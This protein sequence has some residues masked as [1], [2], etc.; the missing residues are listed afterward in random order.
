MANIVN[1][2]SIQIHFFCHFLCMKLITKRFVRNVFHFLSVQQQ[3]KKQ[4]KKELVIV[5][6]HA[7]SSCV[8]EELLGSVGRSSS[9]VISNAERFPRLVAGGGII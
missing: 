2:Q 1:T 6:L 3:A 5:G 7:L 4:V 9:L 8:S